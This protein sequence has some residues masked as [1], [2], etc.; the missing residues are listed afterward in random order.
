MPEVCFIDNCSEYIQGQVAA[1]IPLL[2]LFAQ[3]NP[4]VMMLSKIEMIN[5]FDPLNMYFVV[6][7]R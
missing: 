5:Q 3:L 4:L 1:K 6:N 2:T 7:K